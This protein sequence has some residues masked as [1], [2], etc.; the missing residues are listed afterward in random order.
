MINFKIY[1][2]KF[3][4]DFNSV[5]L[6][7]TNEFSKLKVGKANPNILNDILVNAYDDKLT[8][9]SLANL[10]VPDPRTLIIK[11]YDKSTL[12]NILTAINASNLGLNPQLDADLIRIVFRAPTEED[13]KLMVKKASKL[14]EDA[15]IRVRKIRQNLQDDFKKDSSVLE[16]D[17]KYFQSELDN[18]TKEY[19]K[20]IEDL[21][22]ISKKEIMTI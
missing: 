5:Q 7:L 8:I 17:K 11:P 21:F 9:N 1:K 22:A 3:D 10:S 16:D 18:L 6:W 4:N 12:K 15:K 20:K 14:C 13:R 19:N 2:E